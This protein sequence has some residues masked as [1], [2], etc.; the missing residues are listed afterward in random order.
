MISSALIAFDAFA[1]RHSSCS[2]GR[3]VE[4]ANG[5][6]GNTLHEKSELRFASPEVFLSRLTFR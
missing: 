2:P 6:I 5:V 1:R 4:H 3:L